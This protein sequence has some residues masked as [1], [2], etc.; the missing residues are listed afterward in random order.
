MKIFLNWRMTVCCLAMLCITWAGT[1]RAQELPGV[2]AAR[3]AMQKTEPNIHYNI[4]FGNLHNH[5][6]LSDGDGDPDEAYAHARDVAQLDYFSLADHAEYFL[7]FSWEHRWDTLKETAQDFYAP[8]QF[9]T[10]WGFEWSNPLMG[11][12]CVY[13]TDESTNT[14]SNVGLETFFDWIKDH[15]EGF[16]MFN[17]P[18]RQDSVGT[19]FNHFDLDNDVYEQMVGIETYNKGDAFDEYFYVNAYGSGQTYLDLANT[20]GWRVGAMGGFDHHGTTWG[21]STSFRT[22]VLA[23]ELT[24]EAIIDAYRSRRFYSTENKDLKVD[25]RCSGYPMGSQLTGVPLRFSVWAQD[26]S[27]DTLSEIRFYRNGVNMESRPVTNS[28]AQVY[29]TDSA[30]N[31]NDYYYVIVALTTGD[32]GGHP[33]EAITSPIWCSACEAP[34]GEVEGEGTSEGVAEGEEE[35]P[36]IT[37]CAAV[38]SGPG[39]AAG[40]AAALMSVYATASPALDPNTHDG[41]G[42]G[43]V[44]L[45]Q[46]QLLDLILNNPGLASHCCVSAAWEVNYDLVS[47]GLELV[48]P[49]VFSQTGVERATC[50]AFFA[51]LLTLGEQQGQT[52]L[53]DLMNL[54]TLTVDWQAVDHSAGIY[55]AGQ[56]DADLDLVCNLSEYGSV[57]D[58]PQDFFGFVL[59]AIDPSLHE[60]SGYCSAPCYEMPEGEGQEEGQSEGLLEG[61]G[62]EEGAVEGYEEGVEEGIIEGQ[63]EGEGVEEGGM[64]GQTEGMLEGEG[65]IEGQPEGVQEGEGA[66]EGQPEG[67]QE[68]E[69]DVE[70]QPEGVIEGEGDVEGQVEGVIEGEGGEEGG[71]EGQLEGIEEGEGVPSEGHAEGALEGLVEGQTE[72]GIEGQPEGESEFMTAD[73]NRDHLIGLS[74]LLRLIQFFNSSGFHC[75]TGTEDGYAPGTGGQDCPPHTSDYAPR[76]WHIGLSEILRLIQFFNSGGYHYCPDESTEDGFCPDLR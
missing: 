69:G 34:E 63:P 9:V 1:A 14:A 19:E 16:A 25:F 11:H 17:H 46:C 59:A 18:G 23:V 10:L 36:C 4:Y 54:F 47:A 50:Q 68:G 52:F 74:E 21:S 37:P 26:G 41:D 5:S 35:F 70:G 38:C 7:L 65:I 44:D 53:L 57:V 31:A 75:A 48:S 13:N 3:A 20:K 28:E 56:G 76:D 43:I 12:I 64:E 62:A 40:V 51:G 30:P 49:E 60:D 2:Q 6:T 67:V 42:N 66:V 33:D 39:V 73:L 32:H 58:G 29:F 22:A 72:G 71:M 27:G 55:L 24:R 8:G 61:E 45:A 15:S